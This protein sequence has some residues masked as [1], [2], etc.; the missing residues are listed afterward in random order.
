MLSFL[1]N[2]DTDAMHNTVHT[3]D[4]YHAKSFIQKRWPADVYA[5]NWNAST[6]AHI[7]N[8]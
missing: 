7:H 8:P 2:E 5:G 3:V 4:I 1:M 6:L